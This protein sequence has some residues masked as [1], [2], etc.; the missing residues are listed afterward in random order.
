VEGNWKTYRPII[1]NF[2]LEGKSYTRELTII[3]KFPNR[4]KNVLRK[5]KKKRG[6]NIESP[7]TVLKREGREEEGYSKQQWQTRSRKPQRGEVLQKGNSIKKMLLK[8][9]K[10]KY[11]KR[12]GS[13]AFEEHEKPVPQSGFATNRLETERR[14][15]EERQRGEISSSD[16]EKCFI[17]GKREEKPNLDLGN[18]TET[19]IKNSR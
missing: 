10:I 13:V 3:N 16:T 7:E 12:E 5:K 15:K 8:K 1:N 11:S 18:A 19:K 2:R 6:K 17:S 4:K 14:K 9:R